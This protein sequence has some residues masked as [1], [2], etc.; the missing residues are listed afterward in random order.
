MKCYTKHL[1]IEKY[2]K[3]EIP[4]TKTTIT[5]IS[6]FRSPPIASR[7]KEELLS[8]LKHSTWMFLK[9][10]IPFW[11]VEKRN[12]RWPKQ[13]AHTQ[14]FYWNVMENGVWKSGH[15]TAFTFIGRKVSPTERGMKK[16]ELYTNHHIRAYNLF[17]A[18]CFPLSRAKSS[19][20]HFFCDHTSRSLPRHCAGIHMILSAKFHRVRC[21]Y[22]LHTFKWYSMSVNKLTDDKLFLNY[23][24]DNLVHIV[25]VHMH[26]AH[27]NIPQNFVGF[28]FVHFLHP[29]KTMSTFANRYE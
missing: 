27:T 2:T 13:F 21:I 24:N 6:L 19:W 26:I 9:P 22:E 28:C 1:H 7:K 29:L 10:T 3:C 5:Y 14:R 17:Y 12:K 11:W 4:E 23:S 18:H 20:M 25:R 8:S 16:K 15:K